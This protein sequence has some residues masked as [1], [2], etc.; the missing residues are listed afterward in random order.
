MLNIQLGGFEVLVHRTSL[1]VGLSV[2]II[3]YIY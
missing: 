3:R 1:A 2:P